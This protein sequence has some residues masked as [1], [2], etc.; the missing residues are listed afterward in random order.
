MKLSS[1]INRFSNAQ[2]VILTA[3]ELSNNIHEVIAFISSTRFIAKYF[4]VLSTIVAVS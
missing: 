2:A 3:K 4:Q 1:S